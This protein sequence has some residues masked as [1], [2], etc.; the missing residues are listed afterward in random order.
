[1]YDGRS[2]LQI[3]AFAFKITYSFDREYTGRTEGGRM[4]GL[5][6]TG[7]IQ[8]GESNRAVASSPASPAMA[9]PVLA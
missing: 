9:G 4:F 7:R 8:G 6:V 1:M 5:Y 3:S 2:S